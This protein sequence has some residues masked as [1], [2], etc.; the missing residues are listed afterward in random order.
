ML[1]RRHGVENPGWPR[2]GT[3]SAVRTPSDI[4]PT[5]RFDH[6]EASKDPA[7]RRAL[8]V[9]AVRSLSRA[10]KRPLLLSARRARPGAGGVGEARSRN[11]RRLHR[12]R[13]VRPLRGRI[14]RAARS[15]GRC[16]RPRACV[17]TTWGSTPRRGMRS[18]VDSDFRVVDDVPIEESRQ[19]SRKAHAARA[20][21]VRRVRR[22]KSESA[23]RRCTASASPT[24]RHDARVLPEAS[25]DRAARRSSQ[26]C[27][28]RAGT[29]GPSHGMTFSSTN[30][31]KATTARMQTLMSTNRTF[32]M[33]IAASPNED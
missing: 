4:R 17:P 26:P 1:R 10:G 8:G 6:R 2:Y 14:R 24:F 18:D 30:T 3:P 32:I 22:S 16:H 19:K 29:P 31:V 28:P 21:A 20:L 27:E 12:P 5:G 7:D 15:L 23:S 9:A 33:A 13:G 11:L 25:L